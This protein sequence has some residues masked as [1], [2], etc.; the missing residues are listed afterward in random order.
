MK[1][2]EFANSFD[3]LWFSF[4]E[5]V[6]SFPNNGK[7]TIDQDCDGY[8]IHD[9]EGTVLLSYYP[10]ENKPYAVNGKRWLKFSIKKW[11]NEMLKHS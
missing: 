6:P 4:L 1:F 5:L 9:T 10:D 8:H 11:E 3:G 7:W 2:L